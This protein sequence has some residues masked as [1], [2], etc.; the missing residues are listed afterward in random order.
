M[1]FRN[2]RLRTKITALLVSLAALWAFAAWVTLRE[3]VNLVWVSVYAS[4]VSKPMDA[5]QPELQQE[6]RLSLIELASPGPQERAALTAQRIRTDK[7]IATFEGLARGSDVKLA[8]S[9][10]LKASINAAFVRFDG[11]PASRDTIDSGLMDR[12]KAAAVYTDAID[13]IFQVND[14]LATLDDKAFAKDTRT[15]IELNRARE[16]VSQEDALVSG[17]LTARRFNGPDYLQFAQ[18]VGA[19]RYSFSNVLEELQLSDPVSYDQ[20]TKSE[21]FTRLRGLEDLLLQKGRSDKVQPEKAQPVTAAEWRSVADPTL[22]DL[23]QAVFGGG[24]R[25]VKRATPIA[26]AVVIRLLLAG[27]LGLLAVVSSIIV[28]IT[29]TRALM[30]QLEKLRNA[31]RELADERLPSVVERL[32]HGENVDVAAEAPPLAFGD[33]EIGQVGK[34]FNAVQETAIRTAVEQAELRRGFRDTLLALARRTQTLVHR[35]LTMLD[36]MERREIDAE[37]LEDLFRVDHLATRMRRNAENLIVLSGATPARGWRRSVPMVDVVRA[38]V[39]EVEDYTRVTVMP[40]GD[41]ALT[42]RAVGDVIH[43]LA[44]LIENAVSFSP[45]YT[46]VQIAGSM[47]ASGY[48]IEVEDRGLGMTDEDLDAVNERVAN[49]P[50]FS[51]SSSVHLGLYVVGRLAERYGVQVS[52][53]RSAYGGTTAVVLIPR[54]LVTEDAE[55]PVPVGVGASGPQV[56]QAAQVARSAAPVLTAVR[57]PDPEPVPEP[58]DPPPVPEMSHTPSGLPFRVPQ[59]SLAAPLRVDNPPAESEPDDDPGRSP[60]EIRRIVGSY[61]IGTQRGRHAAAKASAEPETSDSA[62]NDDEPSA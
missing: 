39:G 8:E 47:A 59:A 36:T 17:V 57:S 6:R 55:F 12:T 23:S 34:A 42:G 19:E 24:D 29:T 33:D 7:A 21:S 28:T 46:E 3:G 51:P 52:L 11:I 27:G 58:E 4:G 1:R 43:L 5:L 54:E 20:V 44:E 60:E 9:A 22:S 18:I 10:S 61:Q 38:A 32:G 41:V 31:A 45:P 2:S 13:V 16:I 25:L 56:L 15:L 49:T 48:A 26:I 40:F 37:E 50:D 53:K 62:P 14:Q 35:Q 30:R